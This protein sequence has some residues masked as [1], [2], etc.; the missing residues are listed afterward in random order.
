MK[1]VAFFDNDIKIA[2]DKPS[3]DVRKNKLIDAAG[4]KGDKVKIAAAKFV[5]KL[6]AQKFIDD[7][8][9]SLDQSF[10]DYHLLQRSALSSI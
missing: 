9:N 5:G 7:A 8:K 2:G 3:V 10:V 6:V 4:A 1:K